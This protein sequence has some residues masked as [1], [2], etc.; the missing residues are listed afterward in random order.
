MKSF[1][2]GSASATAVAYWANA[3]RSAALSGVW[4]HPALRTG[5]RPPRLDPRGATPSVL[6]A[7]G[8][9]RLARLG[10][11]G[12]ECRQARLRL[13]VRVVEPGLPA[14]KV[15]LVEGVEDEEALDHR[16]AGRE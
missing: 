6:T 16:L 15:A 13:P 1:T 7:V 9:A 14:G 11:R 5:R 10:G 2:Y 3:A 4:R 12:A 8:E